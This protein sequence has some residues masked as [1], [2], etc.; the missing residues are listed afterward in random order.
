MLPAMLLLCAGLL[1]FIAAPPWAHAQRT[2]DRI[3]IGAQAGRPSGLTAKLYRHAQLAYDLSLGWN[4]R[5][6]VFVEAHRTHEWPLPDSP[7]HLFVGPGLFAGLDDAPRRN[8]ALLGISG[9]LGLN[10]FRERFEVF[11]QATPRMRLYPA[12]RA[13]LGGGVGLR[14][15]F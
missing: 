15:F 5:D 1:P 14:Y 7:L 9:T 11:M 8:R 3:G 6:F 10:F 13:R 2:P 4:L 12:T